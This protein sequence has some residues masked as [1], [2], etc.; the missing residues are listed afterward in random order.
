MTVRLAI[1]ADAERL[2]AIHASA[3][4]QAWTAV[5]FADFLG[6]GEITCLIGEAGF[7]LIRMVAGEA[8]VL[9]L[10][11]EPAK[12]R[13]G[14]ARTLLAAA[15]DRAADGGAEAAFLEVASDNEAAISLYLG[16]GFRQMGRRRDYYAWPTGRQDALVLR[17]DLSSP[18]A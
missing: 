14:C 1:P 15:L 4:D 13:G 8:E 6:R 5:E 2:A 18:T 17:R 16:A 9:T 7:I 11:V 3:F 12:R 10:A